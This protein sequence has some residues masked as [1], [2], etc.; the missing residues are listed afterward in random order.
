MVIPGEIG[1]NLFYYSVKLTSF[2]SQ[3][4]GVTL[5]D[6]I[7]LRLTGGTSGVT[8][9]V[10]GVDYVATDGTDPNTLYVKYLNSGTN[11]TEVKFTDGE[12]ISVATT[13]QESNNGF[14]CYRYMSYRFR[15]QMLVQGVYYING[16][17]VQCC[18]NKL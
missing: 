2:K 4:V 17:H 9:K 18:T 6:L 11:N 1:Y 10:I 15:T 13:L 12:T 3:N 8:A 5:N 7:G 14:C 16:F